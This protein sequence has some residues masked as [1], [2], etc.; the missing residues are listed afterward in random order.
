MK[1]IVCKCKTKSREDLANPFRKIPYKERLI[2]ARAV[3]LKDNHKIEDLDNGYMKIT[4]I[5]E[6]KIVK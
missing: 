3:D 1:K 4:P 6:S 2:K 5:D